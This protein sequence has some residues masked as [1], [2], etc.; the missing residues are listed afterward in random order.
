VNRALFLDRDGTIIEDRGYMGDPALVRLIPGAAEAL[1]ALAREGWKLIIVS[2]QSGVGRGLIGPRQMEAVHS[3]FLEL[4]RSLG[5]PITDS[6]FCTHAPQD[7]CACRKPSP[8]L[9]A[10]AA[11]EHSL[12]LSAS[13]MVGD[14]EAD[15]LCGRNAGCST[16][17]LSNKGFRVPHDLP[18]F[19]AN[20]WDEIYKRLSLSSRGADTIHK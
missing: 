13:W 4:M 11:H 7:A 16:I 19:I 5:V 9:L 6:L 2:N 8:L 1:A 17:W 18:D 10:R 3:R 20:D 14:R 12:D 15:I